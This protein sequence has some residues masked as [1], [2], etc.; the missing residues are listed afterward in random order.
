LN[1]YKKSEIDRYIWLLGKK[2]Y[3]NNY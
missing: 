2:H 3:P 1:E